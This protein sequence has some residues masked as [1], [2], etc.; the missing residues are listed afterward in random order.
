MTIVEPSSEAFLR[1]RP[2]KSA[3]SRDATPIRGSVRKND[4]GL[5]R[6]ARMEQTTGC[7]VPRLAG[8]RGGNSTGL[9]FCSYRS[10]SSNAVKC[11]PAQPWPESKAF[12]VACDA[13][14]RPHAVRS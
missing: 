14:T 3:E 13:V 5:Q 1:T 9:E 6:D 12:D 4:G 10:P 7:V 8:G 11:S 2:Q